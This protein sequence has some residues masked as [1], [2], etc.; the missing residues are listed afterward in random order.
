MEHDRVLD[1]QVFAAVV[2]HGSFSKAVAALGY[3]QPG[4]V[5]T[6]VAGVVDCVIMSRLIAC[7]TAWRTDL[8]LSGTPLA[9]R[10]PAP[11]ARPGD[12][13]ALAIQERS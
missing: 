4:V 3:T 13:R 6:E 9:R 8:S 10:R 12:R 7:W 11:H 2:E 1:L 5:L